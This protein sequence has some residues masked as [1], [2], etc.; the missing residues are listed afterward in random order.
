M[1]IDLQR[2]SKK[3]LSLQQDNSDASYQDELDRFLDAALIPA[4]SDEFEYWKN[5]KEYF[6]RLY[7]LALMYLIIP[8]KSV[9]SERVFSLCGLIVTA[10]RA[11]HVNHLV[12]LNS[13][14]RT[15]EEIEKQTNE[16][17]KDEE[18]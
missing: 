4:D 13:N 7:D 16:L 3:S 6:P 17:R 8:E 5:S 18:E 11:E 1:S 12:F 2:K 10:E 15:R 9:P 14:C